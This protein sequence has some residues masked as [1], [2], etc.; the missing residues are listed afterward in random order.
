MINNND[1]DKEMEEKTERRST[2]RGV[3]NNWRKTKNKDIY[4]SRK[5]YKNVIEKIE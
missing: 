3:N 5:K 4:M 2:M 1:E